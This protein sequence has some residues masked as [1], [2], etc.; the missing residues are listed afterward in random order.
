VKVGINASIDAGT[1]IGEGAFIGPGASV[2][3]NIA[4]RSRIF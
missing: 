2:R 1:I 4:P 3:G